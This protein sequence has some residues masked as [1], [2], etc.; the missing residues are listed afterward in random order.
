[1]AVRRR[2]AEHT[3]RYACLI[4][5]FINPLSILKSMD[6]DVIMNNFDKIDASFEIQAQTQVNVDRR[7]E[8]STKITSI[9]RFQINKSFGESLPRS[10]AFHSNGVPMQPLEIT[11]EAATSSVNLVFSLLLPQAVIL[12]H[13]ETSTQTNSLEEKNTIDTKVMITKE[14]RMINQIEKFILELNYKFFFKSCITD[15]HFRRQ[16]LLVDNVLNDLV[17]RRL[18]H[19]G[20]DETSFLDVKWSIIIKT[21]VKFIPT[22]EDK[23]RFHDDL[24]RHFNIEYEKYEANLKQSSL[25]PPNCELSIYGQNFIR[26]PHYQTFLTERKI[27]INYVQRVRLI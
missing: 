21:Y 20:H 14:E 19:E 5:M 12:F 10:I 22:A 4:Q 26:Q 8:F 25:L 27:I 7:A 18:L 9:I 13:Y 24:S 11:I 1:M 17:K 15:R 23:E 3:V 16:R 6:G 2:A